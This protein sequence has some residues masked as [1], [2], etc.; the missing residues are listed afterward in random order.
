MQ[1]YCIL[2]FIVFVVVFPISCNIFQC[3]FNFV[4][5]KYC[6]TVSEIVF[7]SCS[8]NVLCF[9]LSTCCDVETSCLGQWEIVALKDKAS[10]FVLQ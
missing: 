1:F 2:L 10:I 4:R 6:V 5:L 3:H 7:V 8:Y 9:S